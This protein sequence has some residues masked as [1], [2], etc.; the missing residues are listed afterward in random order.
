MK[1]RIL[2]LDILRVLACIMVIMMHAPMSSDSANGIFTVTWT[3]ITMPC[4]GLFFAVSG[5]LL[6]P[7]P[8]STSDWLKRRLNKVVWPTIIWTLLYIAVNAITKDLAVSEIFRAICSIPFSA[9][10]H[11]IL[12][13]MYALIALY[14]VAPIISPWVEKVDEKTLRIYIF[15]WLITLCYPYLKL[16]VDTNESTTGILYYCSGYVGY[17]LL[18]YYLHHYGYKIKM[19]WTI[20]AFCLAIAAPVAVKLLHIENAPS[21]FEYL[22]IFVTM[23]LPFWWKSAEF[24]EKRIVHTKSLEMISN[25][26]FGIYLIHI[27]ILRTVLQHWSVILNMSNYYIQTIVCV[28]LTFCLSMGISYLISKLPFGDYIIG[29]KIKNNK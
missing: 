24:V 22:N 26:S 4:I 15:F 27:F 28:I 6:L 12:W 10:G 20:V 1:Q 9:Q 14:I 19:W 2:H 11:G 25:L 13:F 8:I 29:F 5:A 7:S 23:M 21:F 3:Y 16:V 17:F 18:G